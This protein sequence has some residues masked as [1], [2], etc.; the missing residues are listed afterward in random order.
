MTKKNFAARSATVIAIAGLALTGTM[1]PAMAQ[2]EQG[3]VVQNQIPAPNPSTINAAATGSI[4]INKQ[5]NTPTGAPAKGDGTDN[6]N[7]TPMA[8]VEFTATRLDL[9]LTNPDDFAAAAEVRAYDVPEAL[10]TG[11][12]TYTGTTGADG[13]VNW[14]DLPLGVYLVEETNA[15]GATVNEQPV[16]NHV[17]ARPFLVYVPFVN[18]EGNGWNY[19]VTVYPKNQGVTIE[20]AVIDEDQHEGDTITYPIVTDIPRS[21]GSVTNEDGTT[22]PKRLSQYVI[23]DQLDTVQL[24]NP[25][26]TVTLGEAT[27]AVGADYTLSTA[28]NLVRVEFTEAG[29]ERLEASPAGSVVTTTIVAELTGEGNGAIENQAELIYHDPNWDYNADGT[30]KDTPEEPPRVPSNKVVTYLG[31][32]QLQKLD[33]N[34]AGLDGATFGVYQCSLVDGDWVIEGDAIETITSEEGGVVRTQQ[35]HV[36]D[37][38]NNAPVIDPSNYCLQETEAPAGYVLD[39]RI[40]PV[41]LQMG[42]TLDVLDPEAN[43][44]VSYEGETLLVTVDV[45]NNPLQLENRRSLISELP[46]TGG[47]G[48]GLFTALGALLLAIAA[49]AARRSENKA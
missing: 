28:G 15:D 26:V 12:D 30:P 41:N 35:L 37:W 43:G 9:D 17:S 14:V 47:M 40:F 39:N 22:S 5:Y 42:S 11:A 4:T 18:A 27:L 21:L 1:G 23:E 48:I 32:I 2:P 24:A 31:E 13:I 46:L 33:E 38:V 34:G 25:D 49:Y 36:T 29:L 19:D 20:K 10:L 8:G 45:E 6:P 16:R 7:G 44:Y 3:G